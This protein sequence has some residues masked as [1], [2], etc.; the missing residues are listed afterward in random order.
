MNLVLEIKQAF[1][2]A[3]E[4]NLSANEFDELEHQ[5]F[6][7]QDQHNAIA[8]ALKQGKIEAKLEMAEKLLDLLDDGA[9]SHATGLSLPEIAELRSMRSQN[10]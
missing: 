1:E 4:G 3:G 2:F 7:I 8:K 10:Q 9:I 5:E 6:F